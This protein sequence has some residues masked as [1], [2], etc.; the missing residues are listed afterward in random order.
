M[1]QINLIDPEEVQVVC[2]VEDNHH[3][4]GQSSKKVHLPEAA[5]P[6]ILAIIHRA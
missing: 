3:Y 5:R 4:N 2:Q 6:A 1:G